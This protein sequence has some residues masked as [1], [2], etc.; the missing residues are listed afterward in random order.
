MTTPSVE[1]IRSKGMK[2]TISGTAFMGH[3]SL[4]FIPFQ[5]ADEL[6]LLTY[7]KMSLLLDFGNFFTKLLTYIIAAFC[8]GYEY[9]TTFIIHRKLALSL[10]GWDFKS[11]GKPLS[12][13]LEE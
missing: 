6:S 10:C 1:G 11:A 12:E 4:K 7:K 9:H 8:E 5:W 2:Q 13:F 3:I